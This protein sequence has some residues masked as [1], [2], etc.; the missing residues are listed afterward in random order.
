[1]RWERGQG[2]RREGGFA[3]VAARFLDQAA[4]VEELV[5]VERLLFV[6][7]AAAE[8]EARAHALAAAERARRRG[9]GGTAGPI[10]EQ[11]QDD[12]V[13]HLR[14]LLAPIFPRDEAVPWFESRAG[15]AHS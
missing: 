6:P 9:L 3:A 7:R 2:L 5:A 11:R 10:L 8:R 4:L 15:R 14:P 1:G 12:L 13:E